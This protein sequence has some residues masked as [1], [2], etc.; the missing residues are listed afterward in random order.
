MK[1]IIKT[2]LEALRQ[3]SAPALRAISGRFEASVAR[4][5]VSRTAAHGGFGTDEPGFLM[6]Q[7]VGE[8]VRLDDKLDRLRREVTKASAFA[9]KPRIAFFSPFPPRKS[10]VSDY[11]MFLLE[12]LTRYYR[13]DLFHDAGYEPE[14]GS[15]E[16]A[17]H[18]YRLFDRLASARDYHCAVYQ[19]GNSHYHNFMYRTLLRH[20]GLVTLHDF[21]LGGFHLYYG[22]GLTM[23]REE[24][25]QWHGEDREEIVRALEEWGNDLNA[26]QRGCAA[27][28]WYLNRRV[29]DAAQVMIVHSP[30]CE[31]RVRS[32][33][34][35]YADRTLVVPH[36][37][38][39]RHTTSA[40]RAATRNRFSL[41]HDA[42]IIAS[43]GFVHPDKMSPQALD[44]YAA[45]ARDVPNS[46]F[47]FVGEEADGGAVQRHADSLG[48]TDRVRFLGHQPA[49]AFAAL[50]AVTDLGV[51]LRKP[52]TNG[53]TSGALLN[54]LAA[55]V[56]TVVT[57]V[58]TFSDYPSSVVRKIHWESEG[59]DGLL[60]A[61][62]G[63]ATMSDARE[64]LGWSALAYVK[65][66]HAWAKV[67][68][69]YRDAIERCHDELSR[70]RG[71]NASAGA[72]TA[73]NDVLLL[74]R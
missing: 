51:N 50:I 35:E 42:L 20:R 62:Q 27:R 14:T 39:P 65:A 25:L 17:C 68:R 21:C 29:L 60:S 43:F 67:G 23:I 55:G 32:G 40:E 71:E 53:E 46:L 22:S 38:H 5:Y 36:G 54:L 59:A 56:A 72:N 18:D 41:P 57:D 70:S 8:A 12:E 1:R 9:R 10:G 11:S 7:A 2:P 63:L 6:D 61:M 69:Q 24:L 58:D 66:H 15:G 64:E 34:A 73:T 30:W 31:S 13:V 19:M 28:G 74:N 26:I 48:L 49:E 16:Y 47:V 45:I 3:V 44:A 4:G 52:P 33:S 37:I